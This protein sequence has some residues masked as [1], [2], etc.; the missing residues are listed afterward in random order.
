[1][2]GNPKGGEHLED[3]RGLEGNIKRTLKGYD[4]KVWTV[5]IWR[6]TGASA[7]LL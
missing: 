3:V 1:M 5:L 4:G 7:G 2:V 6:R